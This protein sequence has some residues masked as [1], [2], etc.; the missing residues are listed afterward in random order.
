MSKKLCQNCIHSWWDKW[1]N[2]L[3]C[4]NTVYMEKFMEEDGSITFVP[5]DCDL[6]N[7]HGDCYGYVPKPGRHLSLEDVED[8]NIHKHFKGKEDER[9]KA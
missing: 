2:K 3:K 5:K 9:Q 1:D 8:D 7:P 4:L 6:V